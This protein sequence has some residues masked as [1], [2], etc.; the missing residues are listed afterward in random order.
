[1]LGALAKYIDDVSVLRKLLFAVSHLPPDL[2]ALWEVAVEFATGER[3]K[4]NEITATQ[5]RLFMENIEELDALAFATDRVLQKELNNFR[6][7]G[8]QPMGVILMSQNKQCCKCGSSLQLRRDR[9]SS[10]VIYDDEM[11][12]VPGSHYHKLCTNQSCGLTQFYGYVSFN[13]SIYYN[14]DW[15]VN[16]YFV[17]SRES[18]FS[19]QLLKRF[20][21]EILIGQMSFKQCADAY[22]FLH[23][24]T[25]SSGE[26][27]S[28]LVWA[29]YMQYVHGL[30]QYTIIS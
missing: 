26:P 28:E 24:H 4:K 10:V 7:S 5:A 16:P 15:E 17:S 14:L 23:L 3:V 1:M 18:V 12:T 11:G 6:F 27:V 13:C 29:I 30:V 19:M 9:P 21:S 22:N 20:D 8:K 25:T 2:P